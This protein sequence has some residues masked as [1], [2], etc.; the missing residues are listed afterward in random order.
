MHYLNFPFAETQVVGGS[1]ISRSQ[2]GAEGK[3]SAW[4]HFSVK[5]GA[6]PTHSFSKRQETMR[7]TI[8]FCTTDT[9]KAQGV[10]ND[11]SVKVSLPFFFLNQ[12]QADCLQRALFQPTQVSLLSCPLN[13]I[14]SSQK[15]AHLD[16]ANTILEAPPSISFMHVLYSAILESLH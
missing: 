3:G 11:Q 14:M 12:G 9:W 7:A 8:S 16:T 10:A 1:L 4:Q 15:H 2:Q 6:P 13:I 5:R